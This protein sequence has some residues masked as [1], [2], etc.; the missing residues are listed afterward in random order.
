MKK[1]SMKAV[2]KAGG[3]SAAGRPQVT[4]SIDKMRKDDDRR[5]KVEGAMQT[6]MRADEL[7]K[8]KAL[9][10]DVEALAKQQAAKMQ[11]LCK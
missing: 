4:S 9:M 7:K 6:L 11:N 3:K 10:K 1:D 2:V 8:D 5:W